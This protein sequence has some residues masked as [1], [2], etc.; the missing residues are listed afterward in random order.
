MYST[1]RLH[2]VFAYRATGHK[3]PQ[4]DYNGG[5]QSIASFRASHLVPYAQFLRQVGTPV[6]RLLL[7]ARLPTMFEDH[8]EAYLPLQPALRFLT[9]ASHLEG[10]EEIGLATTK[11]VRITDL[12]PA[13]VV[14]AQA[15]PTL[16]V[17]L[18]HYCRMGALE[19]TNVRF[20]LVY[21]QEQIRLCA[22]L[23]ASGEP[24]GLRSAEWSQNMTLAAV[25]RAFAG[26]DWCPTEM[27]FTSLLPVSLAASE[28][29]PDT[30]FILGRKASW[31]TMPRSMLSLAPNIRSIMD[32]GLRLTQAEPRSN[33][34]IDFANS[35]KSMLRPYLPD[36]YPKIELAA[37]I[38]GLSV[39]TL[40]RRLAQQGLSYSALVKHLRY[41]AASQLLRDSDVRMIDAAN[42]LGWGS[43]ATFTRAFSDIAGI[44][45]SEYRARNKRI[46]H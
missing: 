5:V 3:P 29:F 15:S 28:L 32:P 4:T 17:A 27:A 22:S 26:Q 21:G 1:D 31:I 39:R 45:P 37:E 10:I 20:W 36:G 35:L 42:E 23:K 2:L 19:N 38:A 30:R 13:F 25:V 33:R 18:E 8:L 6:E 9:M 7:R 24:T 16:N 12:N 46:I 41:E 43:P 11:D 14:A 40:Q 44:S 34:A